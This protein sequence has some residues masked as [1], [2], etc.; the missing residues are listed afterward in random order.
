[1]KGYVDEKGLDKP[2][3][4]NCKYEK[5]MTVEEPCYSCISIM[6]LA[7]H[8]PNCETEFAAFEAKP[9]EVGES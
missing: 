9:G 2:P 5:N 4:R 6:D 3:C 1:M 7:S 8:K